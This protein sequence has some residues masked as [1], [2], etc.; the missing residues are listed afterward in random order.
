MNISYTIKTASSYWIGD[1][2]TM[3]YIQG[4]G[5][6]YLGHSWLLVPIICSVVKVYLVISQENLKPFWVSI[7]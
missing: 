5:H 7:H 4:L 2:G 6:E 1:Q 3:C